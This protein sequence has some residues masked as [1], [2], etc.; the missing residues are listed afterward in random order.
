[1]MFNIFSKNPELPIDAV[2]LSEN[3]RACIEDMENDLLGSLS[4]TIPQADEDVELIYREC[5]DGCLQ[6]SAKIPGTLFTLS[7]IFGKSEWGLT[8]QKNLH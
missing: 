3:A 4:C 6:V 1:M 2:S 5:G 7:K 8:A